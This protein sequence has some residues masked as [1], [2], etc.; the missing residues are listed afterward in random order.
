MKIK[1][2][3]SRTQKLVVREIT[4]EKR[5]YDIYV[6]PY[7][8]TDIER[9]TIREPKDLSGIFEVDGVVVTPAEVEIPVTKN[10]TPEEPHGEIM[11]ETSDEEPT[12]E[13]TPEEPTQDT[14]P[15]NTTSEDG[16]FVCDICKSEFA[17]ARGLASHKNRA[18]PNN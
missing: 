9:M 7:G 14:T 16:V 17:S 8:T 15:E 3:T 2:L 11:D 12:G 6:T 5:V 18:H 4:G 13:P 1:N 10:P